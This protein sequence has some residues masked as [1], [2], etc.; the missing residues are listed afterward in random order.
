MVSTLHYLRSIKFILQTVRVKTL[1]L[2]RGD[3]E[4]RGLY[5]VSDEMFLQD[6]VLAEAKLLAELLSQCL[7]EIHF[8]LYCQFAC[9]DLLNVEL[10]LVEGFTARTE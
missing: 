6:G 10:Y 3:I 2:S 5:E 7:H 8:L 9:L 1:V 4:A